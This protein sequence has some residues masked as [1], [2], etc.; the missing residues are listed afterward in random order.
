M[1][2]FKLNLVRMPDVSFIRW[3][4][5]DNPEEIENPTGAFLEVAPDL[6][7]EV[8][9]PSN[10][11]REMEIKLE[12]YGKAGVELAWY[13]YPKRREVDVYRDARAEGMFTVGMD[14][15][16]DGGEVVTGFLL[17]VA[18]IFQQRAPAGRR[19]ARPPKKPKK[20]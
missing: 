13:V 2:G 18:K 9:S 7:V 3:D 10:T 19:S 15:N 5:E 20:G 6:V 16:L 1:V 14:G 8:M 4:S 17:P 12:E 11:E